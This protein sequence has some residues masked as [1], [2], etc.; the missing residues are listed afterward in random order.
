MSLFEYEHVGG[1]GMC[2]GRW[3]GGLSLFSYVWVWSVLEK[4]EYVRILAL[5][6]MMEDI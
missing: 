3:G 4:G 5:D 2:V 6:T 1:G